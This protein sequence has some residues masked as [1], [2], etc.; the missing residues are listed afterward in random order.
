MFFY[1]VGGEGV[2]RDGDGYDEC[3][4]E[5]ACD[6]G[7]SG[8]AEDSLSNEEIRSEYMIY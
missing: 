7:D 3:V 5:A 1:G 4:V 6:W 2:L 8:P